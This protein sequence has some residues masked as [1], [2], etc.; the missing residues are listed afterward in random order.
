MLFVGTDQHFI[1]KKYMSQR[2][3]YLFI[4]IHFF[5]HIYNVRWP[6][7]G[8]LLCNT[9]R[10]WN[11]EIPLLL[12]HVCFRVIIPFQ[13]F[14]ILG[15]TVACIYIYIYYIYIL[16]VSFERSGSQLLKWCTPWIKL[17]DWIFWKPPNTKGI[18]FQVFCVFV[19]LRFGDVEVL[20]R[21]KRQEVQ[22]G[23]LP[24]LSRAITPPKEVIY[25]P[26]YPFIWPLHPMIF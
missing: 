16:F 25:N 4:Y 20:N 13:N 5:I 17:V 3:V 2:C 23:P 26:S 8:N 10:K 18:A 22:A 21:N 11:L 24:V 1:L 14:P 12:F 7:L 6:F 15:R 19:F 9:I